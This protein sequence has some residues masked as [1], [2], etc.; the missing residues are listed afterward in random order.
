MS[1]R[2]YALRVEGTDLYL[3]AIKTRRGYS[4]TKPLPMGGKYGPRL[5]TRR[6]NAVL[7]RTFWLKGEHVRHVSYGYD[8]EGTPNGSDETFIEPRP[9]RA[10]VKLEIVSFNLVENA[11]P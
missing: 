9:E 2:M 6:Q 5:F 10:N 11:I 8:W 1:L 7:A 4:S 3:P